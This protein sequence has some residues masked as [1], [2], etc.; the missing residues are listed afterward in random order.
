[1]EFR[2]CEELKKQLLQVPALA[3]PDLAKPFKLYIP[4]RRGITLGIL[5]QKLGPLIWE[6][7]YLSK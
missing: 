1:M 5:G 3:L 7:A 4:E 2:M 6:G